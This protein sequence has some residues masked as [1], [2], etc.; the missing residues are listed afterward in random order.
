MEDHGEYEEAREELEKPEEGELKNIYLRPLYREIK[1]IVR[2]MT[3]NEEAQ[4]Y[5][6]YNALKDKITNHYVK[7]YDMF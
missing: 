1:T 7:K 6:D 3:Y 2:S 5:L 4:M